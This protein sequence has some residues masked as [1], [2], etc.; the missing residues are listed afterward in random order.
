LGQTRFSQS[1]WFPY[2]AEQ[3]FDLAADIERYPEFL[4]HWP[5]A[6]IRSR[7]QDVLHVLQ[8]IDLGLRRFRFESRAVLRRPAHLHIDSASGPFRR[9]SID[10][11]FTSGGEGGC[12]VALAV[13]IE[14][15]SALLE[16]FAGGLMRM[17]TQDILRRF[18]ERAAA[19]YG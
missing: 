13:E 9:L 4:P 10:W 19:L 6:T 5:H 14:M 2:T 11:R 16:A 8:E 3:M 15:R 18:R 12:T 7:E 17:M 1:H